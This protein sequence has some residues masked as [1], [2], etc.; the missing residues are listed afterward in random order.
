V[1][2][3]GQIADRVEHARPRGQHTDWFD[4]LIRFGLV[5]F[6]VVHL[7]LAWLALQLAFGDHS[8]NASSQGA[9][10]ELASQPF[11]E[12]LVWLVA[13]GMFLLVGWRLVE[14]AVGH[15]DE[16]GAKRTGKRIVSLGKAVVYGAIGASA[17]QIAIGAGSGG[18][19]TDSMT[20]KLMDLPAGRWI[21]GIVGLVII[22][23]GTALVVRA[24]TDAFAEN[25]SAEG[26]S[27][28]SGTAY[29]WFGRLGYCAKGVAIGIVGGLFGYAALTHDP[30]KSGGL[31][32]ALQTVLEQP[33]GPYLLTV[34][35]VGI[36]C[37]GLFCFA[38]ARHLSR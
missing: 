29:L 1:S 25:L 22:G 14:A 13:L 37:F 36:G 2:R 18:G 8:E 20:A 3:L 7:L 11:G 10:R 21:V 30:K 12:V 17:L 15:R 6:G 34:I 23:I 4:H 35:G 24:W 16:D 31:D 27:G 9:I 32:E 26:R 5:A 28:D 33:F 19:G 38:N